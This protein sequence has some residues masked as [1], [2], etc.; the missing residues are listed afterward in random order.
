MIFLGVIDGIT[1]IKF[2]NATGKSFKNTEKKYLE[3]IPMSNLNNILRQKIY[4]FLTTHDVEINIPTLLEE[5]RKK[6]G[7]RYI[8]PLIAAFVIKSVFM[9]ASYQGIAV[10]SGAALILGKITLI[11]SAILGLKKLVS[12]GKNQ[13]TTL[14]IVKHPHYTHSHSH[15][16]SYEEDDHNYHH[17]SS[18]SGE[19]VQ[20]RI[21]SAY[22]PKHIQYRF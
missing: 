20:E 10:M 5:G 18:N 17:R 1:V 21:Y 7:R 19:D 15:S 2:R 3:H 4:D 14:E 22:V 13:S 11:L 16:S 6:K 12:Y 9:A 8:W